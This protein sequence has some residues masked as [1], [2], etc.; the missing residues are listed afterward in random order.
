MPGSF[1]RACKMARK[2]RRSVNRK[3]ALPLGKPQYD[4]LG[5]LSGLSHWLCWFVSKQCAHVFE[6]KRQQS[7]LSL[8]ISTKTDLKCAWQ[9]GI[10]IRVI[11]THNGIN[12][13]AW[14]EWQGAIIAS[15]GKQIKLGCASALLT[16][17]YTSCILLS[18]DIAAVHSH[19][20]RRK[21]I[22]C[23]INSKFLDIV[24]ILCRYQ[25]LKYHKI[26]QVK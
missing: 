26:A 8:N 3:G 15:H 21:M 5:K 18:L 13:Y 9:K 1:F 25:P 4:W 14:N 23:S 16:A 11:K 22:S 6:R 19:T 12:I 17:Y 20:D 24:D 2:Y 10:S 7:Q